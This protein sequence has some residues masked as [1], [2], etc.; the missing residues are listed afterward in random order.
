MAID[1]MSIRPA[2]LVTGSSIPMSN[3]YCHSFWP[4]CVP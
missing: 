1:K 2:H 4:L 3:W